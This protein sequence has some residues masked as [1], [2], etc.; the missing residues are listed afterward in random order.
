MKAIFTLTLLISSYS[1]AEV[2][3]LFQN[4][5]AVLLI[6]GKDTDA[7]SLYGAMNVQFEPQGNLNVKHISYENMYARPV[8]D[9]TCNLALMSGARS[10]TL[11]FFS[12]QSVINNGQKSVLMGINDQFDAP[13]IAKLFNQISNDPHQTEVFRSLDGKLRIW[14]TFNS[15]GQVS[16]FTMSYY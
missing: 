3:A 4:D 6:Q 16:S 1:F 11:K 7:E 14:K 13:D 10:C 15:A 12:P 5:S 8:F 2:G 9:L